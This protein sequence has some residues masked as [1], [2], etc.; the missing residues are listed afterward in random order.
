VQSSWSG[1]VF[2]V[3]SFSAIWLIFKIDAP[4][5][6]LLS[7]E[8]VMAANIH[9]ASMNFTLTHSFC[10]QKSEHCTDLKLGMIFNETSHFVHT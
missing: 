6:H 10:L 5:R 8:N 4:H 3:S 9:Y 7:A 1:S 2:S